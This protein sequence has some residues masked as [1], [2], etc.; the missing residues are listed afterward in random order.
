MRM[1]GI[2][3]WALALTLVFALAFTVT[4][5]QAR[6]F[7]AANATS[8]AQADQAP[9]YVMTITAKRLPAVCKGAAGAANAVYCATFLEADAV[10]EMHETAAGFAARSAAVD[11]D[12]AYNR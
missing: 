12:L 9:Q 5:N 11:A 10:I 8:V 1:S 7:Q 6:H 3:D 4:I 2:E